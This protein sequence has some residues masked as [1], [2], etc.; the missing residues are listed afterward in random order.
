MY[1]FTIVGGGIV[2]LSTAYSL[3]QRYPNSKI[4]VLEKEGSWAAHQ[5]GNNSGVIHS[6]IY[7]K[8]GSY[9][10]EFTKAGK[11]ELIEFCEKHEVNHEVCGKVIVA[12]KKEEIP[13][14]DK[15]YEQGKVNGLDINLLSAEELK[16]VE[17]FANGEKAIYVREAGIVNYKDVCK[18]IVSL[19]EIQSHT[20]KLNS[21]VINIVENDDLVTIETNNESFQSK[22]LINCAGLYSDHVASQ[23]I[24]RVK[25]LKIIPFRGEYYKIKDEKKHI[26]NNLIYPIPNPSFPFMGVHFTR[27]IDGG[28]E[29]GPNAVLSL[30]RE[31]YHKT[32]FQWKEFFESVS[33]PGLWKLGSK[34]W[35]EGTKEMYRSYSKRAFIKD[36]QRLIPVIQR[37][38]LEP[39]PSGVRAQALLKDGRLLDDFY[40][41]NGKNSVHVCNAPSPAATASLSIG[42]AIVDKIEESFAKVIV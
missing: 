15:L 24:D 21:K 38:D 5:T 1:D 39:A 3:V 32:S 31:G 30:R 19:L 2:G 16:E 17:P 42:K 13:H 41:I 10:A 18:K 4:L 11:K 8:P 7:Y 20:L 40:F 25:E 36:A 35:K 33:Y 6:G 12:T 22:F 26:V 37:E 34:Y 28:V 27:M 9:K 23:V 29:V 14:L